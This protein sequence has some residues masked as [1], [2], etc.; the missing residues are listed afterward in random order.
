MGK[1]RLV[2]VDDH[3]IVSKGLTTLLNLVPEFEVV[4][5]F[6]NGFSII[7]QYNDLKPDVILMDINMPNI[8]GYETAKKLIEIDPA[9]KL[10]ILS[11]EIKRY[12]KEKA[13]QEGMKGYVS[14]NADINILVNEIKRVHNGEICFDD[15][16]PAWA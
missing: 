1:I 11:M 4:R 14:K 6:N 15:L 2:L 3:E 12:Y 9:A 7:E 8:N 5:I 16:K 13:L 10:I